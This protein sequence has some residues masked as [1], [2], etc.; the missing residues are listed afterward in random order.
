[1][2]IAASIYHAT[3]CLHA[4]VCVRA[5]FWR[6]EREKSTKCLCVWLK[7]DLGWSVRD[8][9][10]CV[11]E[12]LHVTEVLL[13]IADEF[14]ETATRFS[15]DLARHRGGNTVEARDLKLHLGTEG[16]VRARYRRCECDDDVAVM[17]MMMMYTC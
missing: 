2:K 13:D 3:V 15:C 11:C 16:G 17:I 1:M 7:A 9:C 14:V 4:G 10:V 12:W 8:V 6:R 5:W